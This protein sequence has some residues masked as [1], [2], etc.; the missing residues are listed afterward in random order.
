[1]NNAV[2]IKDKVLL[3]VEE[4]VAY[5]GIGQAK[6]RELTNSGNCPFVVWNG[7]KRLIKRKQMEEFLN[8][9]Y[10]I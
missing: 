5:F 2:L 3:T 10:S 1:M 7:N 9:S 6:V 4:A 8:N